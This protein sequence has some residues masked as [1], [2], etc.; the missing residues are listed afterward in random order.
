MVCPKCGKHV[1]NL[2]KICPYCNAEIQTDEMLKENRIKALNSRSPLT[3]GI[4]LLLGGFIGIHNFYLGQTGL[5]LIKLLSV[6]IMTILGNI[7]SSHYLSI[8]ITCITF[9]IPIL[10]FIELF[11]LYQHKTKT[12]YELIYTPRNWKL[13]GIVG[14]IYVII[15]IIPFLGLH[16]FS[17]SNNPEI[18]YVKEYEY[19]NDITINDMVTS[20]IN[21]PSWEFIDDNTV[22]VSGLVE[23]NGKPATL[24]IGFKIDNE[25]K[26]SIYAMEINDTPLDSYE[27]LGI[28]FMLID[29]AKNPKLIHQD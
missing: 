24:G 16:I 19:D 2:T 10:N 8:L 26:V 6:L 21:A 20:L 29:R 3:A 27:I 13:L 1:S 17:Q 14:I 22:N 5:G 18:D 15:N 12:K 4:L 7:I 23:H 11:S 25:K 9:L 28:T